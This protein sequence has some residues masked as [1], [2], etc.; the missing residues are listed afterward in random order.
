[1]GVSNGK[2]EGGVAMLSFSRRR[3]CIEDMSMF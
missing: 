2:D 1:M 3:A